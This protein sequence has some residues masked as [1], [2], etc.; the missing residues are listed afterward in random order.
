[1]KRLSIILIILLLVSLTGM[2][3]VS[4]STDG[5]PGNEEILIAEEHGNGEAEPNGNG[6]VDTNGN[7]DQDPMD[8]EVDIGVDETGETGNM[9]IYIGLG[10]IV[11]IAIVAIAS[12]ANSGKKR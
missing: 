1:M 12:I 10:I 8:V 2:S 4:A 5:N 9:L 3:L 6:E 7:A 11:I